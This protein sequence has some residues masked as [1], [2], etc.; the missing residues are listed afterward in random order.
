[1]RF[2]VFAIITIV[3]LVGGCAPGQREGTEGAGEQRAALTTRDDRSM[4]YL[5]FLPAAYNDNDDAWPMIV[6]LHGAGERGDDLDLV[7]VHGPP[8]RVQ[9]EPW[10]PFIV[11]SPQCA[12]GSWWTAP[13]YEALLTGMIADVAA[14]HR[15]DRERIYVT[16][17]SMGGYGTW[18]LAGQHPELFAAVVPICGG[19]D[20]LQACDLRDVPVWAFH[21]AKDRVVPV[22]ESESMVEALRACGGDVQLTIYPDAGHD[23]WTETY[24][25]PA[26]YEWL[27]RHR[28]EE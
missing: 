12:A 23:A 20:P 26:L 13:E 2:R 9:E 10:F 4:S 21:G 15:V 27:L 18:Q 7:A 16:G 17:L 11:V 8:K 24:D 25:D 14:A 1:M 28:R 6:F 5:L 22:A 19:G 3:G